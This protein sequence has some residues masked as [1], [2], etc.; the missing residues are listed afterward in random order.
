MFQHIPTP[1]GCVIIKRSLGRGWPKSPTKVGEIKKWRNGVKVNKQNL[2]DWDRVVHT[3]FR[4]I[5]SSFYNNAVAGM[6][7]RIA[8][9]VKRKGA[10][11]PK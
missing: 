10:R 6:E 9:M 4:Q 3:T 1:V 5:P 8:D 2:K 7:A 11:V